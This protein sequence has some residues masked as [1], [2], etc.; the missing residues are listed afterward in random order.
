MVKVN[1]L[2]PTTQALNELWGE[3]P[4]R[5]VQIPLHNEIC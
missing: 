3:L 2:P 4:V 1:N 5:F